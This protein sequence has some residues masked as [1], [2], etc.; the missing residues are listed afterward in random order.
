MNPTT[1]PALRSFVEVAPESHFPIQNLPYGVFRRSGGEPR[2]GVAIGSY[3]L[4]LAVLESERLFH[5]PHLRGRRV[6]GEPRLNSFMALGR[7]AWTEA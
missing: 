5:T 1:S 7:P 4:D 3:V 6:F 2:V